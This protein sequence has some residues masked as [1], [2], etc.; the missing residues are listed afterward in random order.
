M[1]IVQHRK[2][3][4]IIS[5]LLVAGS[6]ILM[7]TLGLNFGIDFTGGSIYEAEYVAARPDMDTIRASL[8]TTPIEGIQAQPVGEK[9]VILR[10]KAINEV[11]KDII[12]QALAGTTTG[13]TT[14]TLVEKRFSSVGPTIGSE[15][16]KKGL[17]ASAIATVLILLFIAYA[18]R[19]VSR[20]VA[21]W[22]YGVV[23]VI[24]LVHDL[25]IVTGLYV[26]WSYFSG[27]EIDALFLT[28]FLTIM[29]LSVND[30]IAVFDR[31][32]ENIR[33]QTGKSFTETVG[34]SLRET[35]SRSLNTSL[36]VIVVLISIYLFG[37]ST[38]RDFAFALTL[39]MIVATY[40]S[41]FIAAP[42]LVTA[43]KLQEK[44]K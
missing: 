10:M 43:E 16:T 35:M 44:K 41:V 27:A 38:T 34:R 14:A 7:G 8:A 3:F 1:F 4:F 36:T 12:V 26:L 22:K 24:K 39:G 17:T 32:R 19:G 31:I 30:V 2:I 9:G 40:S 6:V 33:R 18:F 25:T 20:P 37:G 21:S 15:L 11:E 23:C 42:L 5:L 13:T 29:G 28:A